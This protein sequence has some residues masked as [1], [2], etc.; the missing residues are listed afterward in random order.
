MLLAINTT[1]TA[2]KLIDLYK[3]CVVIAFCTINPTIFILLKKRQLFSILY[4][5]TDKKLAIACSLTILREC[6]VLITIIQYI[7][8]CYITKKSKIISIESKFRL[9]TL[10]FGLKQARCKSVIRYI[11]S[12]SNK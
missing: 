10:K 11:R 1:E 8:V 5:C 6:K 12:D 2:K 3:I 9:T 7:T 4:A